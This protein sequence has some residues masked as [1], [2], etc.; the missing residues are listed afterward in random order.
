MA[1]AGG[2]PTLTGTVTFFLCHSSGRR[3]QTGWSGVWSADVCV[4]DL[5]TSSAV[6]GATTPNDNA[7]GQ[8]CWRAV[9]SGDG[10][11]NGSTHTGNVAAEGFTAVEQGSTPNTPSSPT[12]GAPAPGVSGTGAGAGAG[13]G[14]G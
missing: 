12:G 2:Q 1:G 9:Y 6:T 3:R 10:F 14:G 4:S 8:Y 11:Y 13:G 7:I 5:A